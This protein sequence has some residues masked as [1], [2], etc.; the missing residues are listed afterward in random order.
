MGECGIV[1]ELLSI[2][3]CIAAIV[4]NSFLLLS[5]DL[6][7]VQSY[8]FEGSLGLFSWQVPGQNEECTAIASSSEEDK[9]FYESEI[10]LCARWAAVAG[11]SIGGIMTILIIFKQCLIPLPRTRLL[12]DIC[13]ISVQICLGLVYATYFSKVCTNFECTYGQGT[14]L[15]IL[16][17]FFWAAGGISIRCMR[18]GRYERK[19]SIEIKRDEHPAAVNDAEA[20][21]EAPDTSGDEGG[22][23]EAGLAKYK[24][25]ESSKGDAMSET[26][27]MVVAISVAPDDYKG[28]NMMIKEEEELEE[29]Q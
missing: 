10:L 13:T 20:A 11:L 29:K 1:A 24:N 2:A 7:K 4:T 28:G 9:D 17:Q 25:D 19:D 16:T 8:F 12:L 27:S 3:F 14:L 5:C 22:G 6:W 15:L 23:L 21:E 18:P 26:S